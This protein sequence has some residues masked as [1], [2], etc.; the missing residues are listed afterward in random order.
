MVKTL[1]FC[2]MLFCNLYEFSFHS[3][4]KITI[5]QYFQ[6]KIV[7]F[8]K[9]VNLILLFVLNTWYYLLNAQSLIFIASKMMNFNMKCRFEFRVIGLVI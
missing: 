4:Q 5:F 1:E 2:N 9:K 3:L 6:P 7:N 8:K